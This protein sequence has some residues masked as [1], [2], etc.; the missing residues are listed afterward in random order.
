MEPCL[1]VVCWSIAALAIFASPPVLG[2]PQ[3]Q[4]RGG[5]PLEQQRSAA[6]ENHVGS[7]FAMDHFNSMLVNEMVQLC[8]RKRSSV[9]PSRLAPCLTT[10]QLEPNSKDNRQVAS[11]R[12]EVARRTR[13]RRTTRLTR[14]PF[15]QG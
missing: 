10:S 9:E 15:V 1:S 3:K 14:D 6:A 8:F 13:F 4:L 11:T 2:S 7:W 12:V 5:K